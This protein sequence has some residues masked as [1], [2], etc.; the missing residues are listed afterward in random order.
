MSSLSGKFLVARPVLLEGFFARSVILMLQHSAEGA[1]GLTLNR[2]AQTKDLPFSIF[3]GGPCKMDGLLMIHGNQAWLKPEDDAVPEICPG[4][5]LGTSEQFEKAT[6]ADDGA[7]GKFRIFTGYAGWGPGQL[8]A[9]MQQDAWIVLPASGA[10]IFET[11][12]EEL[13]ERLAPP[14]LPMPS[15]N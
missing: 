2:P 11:P 14:R 6:S 12:S 9:E 3:V 1:L 4:V 7:D 10:V 8:E 5:F 15:M 13:W